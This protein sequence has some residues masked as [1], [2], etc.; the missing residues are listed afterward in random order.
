MNARSII[1]LIFLLL[2]LIGTAQEPQVEVRDTF[3]PNT[4]KIANFKTEPD[5]FIGRVLFR[6]TPEKLK[7]DI[8]EQTVFKATK[9]TFLVKVDSALLN[10]FK[11]PTSIQTLTSE[12]FS[13]VSGGLT[14][15]EWSNRNNIIYIPPKETSDSLTRLVYGF[16]PYWMGDAYKSYYFSLLSRVAYFSY[17]IEAKKGNAT[18]PLGWE[19]SE[20]VNLAHAQNCKVDLSVS[21]FGSANT[22]AFLNNKVLQ[23]QVIAS[24]IGLIKSKNADGINL[25]IEDVSIESLSNYINFIKRFSNELKTADSEFFFSVCLPAFDWSGVY[26]LEEINSFVDLYIVMGYDINGNLSLTAGPNAPLYGNGKINIANSLSTWYAKGLPQKKTILAVPYF[27][28]RWNTKEAIIPSEVIEFQGAVTYREIIAVYK[29]NYKSYNDS[30]QSAS[31]I[32]FNENSNWEQIWYDDEASL[33]QKYDYVNAENL[34]GIGIWALGYDN[35]LPMLWNLLKKKFTV[36]QGQLAEQRN[37]AKANVFNSLKSKVESP[38]DMHSTLPAM[39]RTT[40]AEVD[41]KEI[42]SVI[43]LVAIFALLLSGFA[44]IGF[45]ISLFDYNV[46]EVLFSVNFRVILFFMLIFVFIQVI[47]R[48]FDVLDDKDLLFIIGIVLGISVSIITI[49]TINSNNKNPKDVTP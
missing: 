27:G 11:H 38:I 31:Y 47:L 17:N 6:L 35:G 45:I 7:Y 30:I 23:D 24:S 8:T 33:A 28:Y 29:E 9:D 39:K 13:G 49:K 4:V 32:I 12:K 34:P 26:L 25:N 20:I 10:S 18:I 44:I 2:V 40:I 15:E 22:T 3:V 46:R 16:H 37:A 41:K 1:S 5:N 21:C 14:E 36:N 43:R 19:K 48:I 42:S